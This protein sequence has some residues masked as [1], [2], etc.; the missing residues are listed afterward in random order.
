MRDPYS[1]SPVLLVKQPGSTEEGTSVLSIGRYE[2]HDELICEVQTVFNNVRE[3]Q[4]R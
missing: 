1:V 4:C 2:L 3:V